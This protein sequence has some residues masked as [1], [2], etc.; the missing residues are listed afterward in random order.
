[1]TSRQTLA[2]YLV[3]IALLQS[4]L[5]FSF[6]QSNGMGAAFYFDPRIGIDAMIMSGPMTHEE[7][8]KL[9]SMS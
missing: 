3:T 4:G 5:Y 6:L 1:M 8:L 7:G 2:V 9:E